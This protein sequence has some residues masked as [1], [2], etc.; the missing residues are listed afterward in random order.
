MSLRKDQVFCLH[1]IFFNEKETDKERAKREKKGI[2]TV[3]SK[4]LVFSGVL[5]YLKN[6]KALFIDFFFEKHFKNAVLS[7]FIASIEEYF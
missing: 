6:K 4:F 3:K 7:S 1:G 2:H 5:D